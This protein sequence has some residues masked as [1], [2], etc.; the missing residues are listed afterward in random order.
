MAYVDPQ[1]ITVNAVAQSLARVASGTNSGSFQTNDGNFRLDVAHSYGKRARHTLV[2]RQRKIAADP[3]ISAN[4]AE[5][6]M[7]MRLTFDV[8]SNQG[9]TVAEQKLLNDG[10]AVWLAASSANVVTR[11]LGG[12]N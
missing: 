12:E 2:V 6:W 7:T 9:F 4:N 5:F 10:V 8:P 1:V 3:L 11:L